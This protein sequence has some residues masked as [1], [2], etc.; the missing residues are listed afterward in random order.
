MFQENPSFQ[1]VET[2]FGERKTVNKRILFPINKNSDSTSRS[3]EFVKKYAFT[4]PKNCFHW[5]KYIYKKPIVGERLL[6][7]K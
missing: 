7:K 6:N 3:E 5:Q 4:T 2:D 1:L